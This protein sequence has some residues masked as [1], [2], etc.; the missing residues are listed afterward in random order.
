[1]ATQTVPSLDV[2]SFEYIIK[3]RMK[4]DPTFKDYDF[5]GSGLSAIIRLLASDANA[6]SFMQNMLYGEGHLQ[7]AQQR[8]NVGLASSFLSYTPDNYRAAYLYADIK[9]TPYDAST[10]ASE[11]VMDRKAMFIGAK[12]GSSYNFTV[13][14]PV[15]ASL[16]SDGYYLFEN[17]KLIQGNWLYKTYDVEGSAIDSYTI[18][19]GNVDISHLVVNVQESET[20]DA[21][22][23]FA[24]Y[25]SPFDLSQYARLFFVELGLDGLYTFEFGDGYICRRLDDGNVVFLQYLETAGVDGND[26]T[27]I[28]SAS[29]IAGNNLVDITL[30][31]ERSVG[32]A[33]PETI[34][35]TKRLAPLSY[36]ADGAAV[37]ESDY[38]VLVEKLFS[39]VLRAKAY[40][41]DTL[42]PPDS[43]YVYI[44][45]IPKEGETLSDAEKAD[46]V[47]LLDKYNVGSIT[48]KVVDAE[49][50]YVQ[51]S[52]QIF[53][54]STATAS[55]EEQMK[56]LVAKGIVKW[57]ANNLD[58]FDEIL[59]K[60]IL[61]EAI[62]ALHRAIVSNITSV[63]YKRHFKPV[64]GSLDSFTFDFKRS[65]KS[66]SVLINGFKPLP[67][68]VDFSYYIRD[69]NGV[70]NMYKVSN[71][72]LTKEYLVQAVGVV[73]YS[74]GVVELQQITVSNYDAVG[75]S[76]VVSPEGL[77]QNIEAVNNQVL[78]VGDVDITA[79]VRYVQRT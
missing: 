77:D 78:R 75:A 12:D 34:E 3:Q 27:S 30:V 20:S 8:S 10:A 32:G 55:T 21:T 36:Q 49:I 7:S 52:T 71:D 59:D 61:Q 40:G 17:V 29:S 14:T 28:S 45:V 46:M 66:G 74:T 19:S 37:A 48:P 57:G 23:T 22:F 73:N 79:K 1:M 39:G 50:T 60:E 72:D 2:R 64:Y 26:I 15:S 56:E 6:L 4:S 16:N 67:A 25:I 68:E 5:E 18:P 58:S 69:V 31:S 9:V 24:R 63:S 33:D 43:G 41:G 51:V 76:I 54:D 38:G 13:E 44:A 62:T 42:S 11:I 35:D 70:L 65:L 47:A 53:W